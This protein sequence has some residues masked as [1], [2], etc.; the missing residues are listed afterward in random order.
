MKRA[1]RVPRAVLFFPLENS[2]SRAF[3][4]SGYFSNCFA[5][6]LSCN[7]SDPDPEKRFSLKLCSSPVVFFPL[8]V[9]DTA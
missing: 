8:V 2:P 4:L 6:I 5:Q 1:E 7:S 3:L 9:T